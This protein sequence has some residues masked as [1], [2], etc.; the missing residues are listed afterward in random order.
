MNH[1]RVDAGGETGDGSDD[2][3]YT[4]IGGVRI[5]IYFVEGGADKFADPTATVY[6]IGKPTD[7]TKSVLENV[8]SSKGYDYTIDIYSKWSV[9]DYMNKDGEVYN[10]VRVKIT[11][12]TY[13]KPSDSSI[14][15]SM[16]NPLNCETKDWVDWFIGNDYKNITEISKLCGSEIAANDFKNNIYRYKGLV[17]NG[18]YKLFFEPLIL[19]IVDGN[20][21]F[22]TL[23]DAIKYNQ[24][25]NY[26]GVIVNKLNLMFEELGN[27]AFLVED[28]KPALNMYKNAYPDEN[29]P[30]YEIKYDKDRAKVTMDEIKKQIQP[31]GTIYKSMGVGVVTPNP[32]VEPPPEPVVVSEELPDADVIFNTDPEEVKGQFKAEN[33]DAEKYDVS[34]GIPCTE[35]LYANIIAPEYLKDFNVT[36]VTDSK[37][38]D[39]TVRKT[40]RLHYETWDDDADDCPD[41]SDG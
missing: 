13:K 26:D 10:P 7:F 37:D 33:R 15:S 39:I 32:A 41:C 20:G 9:F 14:I 2:W 1:G 30:A 25:R 34:K 11:P 23:R 36:E 18:T 24:R 31:G 12:Y 29:G 3:A 5:G 19:A 4:T 35:E 40:F 16:P 22:L 21:I 6:Q 27:N 38:Y 8:K 17:L 28:E